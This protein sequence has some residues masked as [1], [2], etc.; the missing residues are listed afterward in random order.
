MNNGGNLLLFFYEDMGPAPTKKHSID[1]IDNDGNYEPG[2]C[3]WATM[4]EQCRNRKGCRFLEVEGEVKTVEE[5]S[6]I[7]GLGRGIL[8]TRYEQGKVT[9]SELFV[10][11][12]FYRFGNQNARKG[13]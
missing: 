9:K 10:P 2:N 4:K 13:K 3:R 6:E 8:T 5:W 12:N 11:S 7:S 1:R